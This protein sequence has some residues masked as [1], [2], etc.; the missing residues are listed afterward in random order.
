VGVEPTLGSFARHHDQ[1][2][3][4]QG[5]G[6]RHLRTRAV[7]PEQGAWRGH[8]GASERKPVLG[9]LLADLLVRNTFS[10]KSA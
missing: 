6:D 9:P 8:S 5:G 1:N 4:R 3:L 2:G 7:R 10:N